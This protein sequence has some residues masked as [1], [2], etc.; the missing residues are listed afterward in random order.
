MTYLCSYTPT[1]LPW[2]ERSWALYVGDR[3]GNLALVY[4]DPEIS[5][6]EP[7]PLVR[8][9]PAAGAAVCPAGHRRDGRRGH[10][11]RGGRVPG[12]ARRASRHGQYLRILEDVPRKSVHRGGVVLTS[13]TPIYTIKRILGIVPIEADGSAHF[14]V[15]ANRNVYFEVLDAEQQEIQRMR[16]VVC[17][18]PGERR[19]CIGCHESRLT[20][21]PNRPLS[22]L[23][24]EPSRPQPPPWG[25]QVISYLRDVQPVINARCVRCHTHDRPANGVILTDDLTDSFTVAYEEL[26]PYLSVA[27]AL[28]W[29]HPDDV[30]PRP[31]YTYGSKASRLMTV[32]DAGHHDLELTADERL[33][34]VNW[35]DA[36]GVYYD[37][38]ESE[39]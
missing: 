1:V 17:L 26:L 12:P 30:D 32:L 31:P 5:C 35:I 27:N 10:A 7:V 34:L 37:R 18:K 3:H 13:G 16:S 20:A 14:L 11:G 23:G 29:D 15:P 38:Y 19:T 21:P 6:A 36:N 33:R 8:A 2:L 28:R 24:R 22:A 25:T 39:A 4:R 9:A